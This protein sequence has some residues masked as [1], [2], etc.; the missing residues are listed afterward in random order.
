VGQAKSDQIKPVT[1]LINAGARALARFKVGGLGDIRTVFAN[2]P[3]KRRERRA[4]SAVHPG[5]AFTFWASGLRFVILISIVILQLDS[6]L[7]R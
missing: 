5:V 7:K 1:Y 2:Q 4:P 6:G 3:L